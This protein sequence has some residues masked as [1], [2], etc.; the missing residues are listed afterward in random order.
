MKDIY[1]FN[2]GRIQQKDYTIQLILENGK[3]KI[4]PIEQI[5]NIHIFSEM[6]LNTSLL[7]LMNQ[8][9]VFLHFYNY[10][11][12]YSGSYVPRRKKISGFVDVKQSEHVLILEKR[13]VIAKKIV[14]SSAFHILRNIRKYCTDDYGIR[15]EIISLKNKIN[16]VKDIPTL[17]GIEGNIRQLYYQTF[18]LIIKYDEFHFEKRVKRPPNDSIN[19][20]ISFGNSLMYTS[21]LSEIY[22]TQLNPAISF[23]HEPG[24]RRFSLSLD[25]AEI[26][27]PLI[28]DPL[29]F[30]LINKRM[31]RK[32][33]FN[34]VEEE[35]CLLNDEGRK[36]F[37]KE[38]ENRFATTI[39]HRK[40]NRNTSYKFLIRLECYKLIK[41]FLED[42]VYKPL[43]AWW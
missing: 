34:Y 7:N 21:V 39:K 25:L 31:I 36:I 22:K 27:K 1:L 28:I 13:L 20:L 2:N 24:F 10:Y 14:E 18:N 38:L 23:L 15:D 8:K 19:A 37:I 41:H 26:F 29:M 35:I 42:E 12:Y 40:L 32:E 9:D 4:V 5:D 3:K 43:Q 17:M 30:T 6:D 11:G 16:E 33:H